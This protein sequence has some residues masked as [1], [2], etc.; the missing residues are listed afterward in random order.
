MSARQ[1]YVYILANHS[2][3]LYICVTNNLTRRVY[4]HN[5]DLVPGFSRK[6][7]IHRLVYQEHCD[8]VENAIAREKQL[9]NWRRDKKVALINRINPEWEDLVGVVTG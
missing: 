9:K 7:K 8:D 4:E 1:Y 6:Y 2:R 3:V 5:H